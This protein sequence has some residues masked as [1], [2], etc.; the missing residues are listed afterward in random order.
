MAC[1][2]AIVTRDRPPALV[3]GVARFAIAAR[4][5]IV[6]RFARVVIAVL[7]LGL[8]IWTTAAAQ[9]PDETYLAGLRSRRLFALA[10]RFCQQR[11][12]AAG[13]DPQQQVELTIE[14]IRIAA[15]QAVQAP[16]AERD[17]HWRR[18]REAAANFLNRQPPHPRQLL[19]RVQDA[20]TPLAEG[21]L[22]RQ[23]AEVAIDPEPPREVARERLREAVRLLE[24]IDKE[25]T[26][27]I[28]RAASGRPAAG[29]LSSGELFSLQHNVRYQLGRA[30]RNQ[31]LCY[32]ASSENWLAALTAANEQLAKPLSQLSSEDPLWW[33][34]RLEQAECH[35]RLKE[36]RLADTVLRE[37]MDEGPPD[38][39]RWRA[40]A[41]AAR[42]LLSVGRADQSLTLLTQVT[43]PAEDAP[44]EFDLALLETLLALG[45]AADDAGDTSRA[46]ELQ[47]QAARQ[48][49]AIEQ[50]QGPYWGRRAELLLVRGSGRG[51]ANL[52]VLERTAANFYRKGQFEDALATYDQAAQLA[53]E[54]RDEAQAFAFAYK[55]GLIQQQ[56][57]RYQQAGE[58]L[59]SVAL[60]WPRHP[61]AAAAHVL[62]AWNMAQ[63]ARQQPEQLATYQQILEEHL[64][65]WPS[66][67]A[68]G[69]AALWLGALQES[70][71]QWAVAVE[72]YARVP[73]G[74][75]QFEPAIQGLIRCWKQLLLQLQEA[76]QPV[77][78]AARQAVAYLE[79]L[80]RT[81]SGDLPE[82]WS[83]VAR[84]AALEAA[85]LQLHYDPAGHAAAE[86]LLR[87]ALQGAPPPPPAWVATARGLLIV[88]VA[89]QP[90]RAAEVQALIRQLAGE[91]PQ[92]LLDILRGLEATSADAPPARRAE[93]GKLQ[94]QLIGLIQP[95]QQ[96]LTSDE[97][98][99]LNK[100]QATAMVLSGDRAAA[101]ELLRQLA[102]S[103]PRDGRIQEEYAQFLL[104]GQQ[105][106]ELRAAVNQWR[107]VAN[108]SRKDSARWWRAKHAI[109]L[110]LYKLG[111]KEDAAQRI[112][113][114]LA[115]SRPESPDMKRQLEE[116]LEQCRKK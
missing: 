18:A 4:F 10:E 51:T 65:T 58:R 30:R 116:L 17:A 64:A 37:V 78:Q 23:E 7:L 38:D 32:P 107:L 112:E 19:V 94:L 95:G 14:L 15:E 41:E 26:L 43:R 42:L 104:D 8:P 87:A 47:K 50:R 21:E 55:A 66:T 56:Q 49:A 22:A 5:A 24:Q 72:A 40:E 36:F 75:E 74:Q 70:R 63:A 67:A 61:Q 6:A 103:Q 73:A 90:G 106:Q 92:Q 69:Q 1:R 96:T 97:Q 101:A 28:P 93:L 89:G 82:R 79:R 98:L 109:S 39:V 77:Q 83:P 35:R 3:F 81:A 44:P 62:A 34:I 20:L 102:T 108:G 57:Q 33:T 13:L 11:L 84:L 9:S 100:I 76:N 88:A 12:A 113:Y 53:A 27:A 48:V 54:A 114:L 46:E 60:A 2:D 71:R 110:A 105:P 85:E 31:A 80:V 115:T 68:A 16:P 52:D 91:Q 99:Q 29:E 86:S 45:K 25:I 111:E 59:R